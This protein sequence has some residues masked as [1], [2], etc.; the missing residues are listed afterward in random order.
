MSSLVVKLPGLLT[1]IQDLG[2]PGFGPMGISPAG[3]ADPVA[4][5]LANLLV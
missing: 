1:T 4:L 3:A 5:R 2:R